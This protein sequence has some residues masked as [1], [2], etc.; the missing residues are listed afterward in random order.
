MKQV[1]RNSS[2]SFLA[3]IRR[4]VSE[5]FFAREIPYGLAVVRIFLPLAMLVPMVYRLRWV[6]ELYS[7][8]GATAQVTS[9]Y[10]YGDMLPVFPGSVAV[11]LYCAMVVLLLLTS[12]GWQTRF[13]IVGGTVLYV[14][15]NMLDAVGTSTK[16]SAIAAD[17]MLA[18]C[19][20]ESGAV[21]S[22]D[23]WRRRKSGLFRYDR[24]S[25]KSAVWPT[26]L[27]QFLLGSIYFG[28]AMTKIHTPE[29]F[30]GEQLRF[31][32]LSNV[33]FDNPFGEYLATM[34]AMLVISAYITVVWEMLFLF[35]V[36]KG[37]ARYVMLF[38][39]AIFH[40]GT[41][42]TLGLYTFPMI[43]ISGYW[44]FA[45]QKDVERLMIWTRSKALRLGFLRRRSETAAVSRS[46]WF[47]GLG[48]LPE[49]AL[50][51]VVIL[52][53]CVIGVEAEYHLDLYQVRQ[54]DGPMALKEMDPN[55]A[56]KM[57]H[58]SEPIREVDKYFSFELG[59]FMVS[60]ILSNSKREFQY[61]EPIVIQVNLNP[62]HGDLWLECNL[63]DAEGRLIERGGQIVTRKMLRANFFFTLNEVL[64]PAEYQFV[65]LSS[66]TEV[67][68]RAF[69]L[70]T[71]FT[72]RQRESIPDSSD[73]MSPAEP[74]ELNVEQFDA[75][76]QTEPIE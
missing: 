71:E 17:I 12:I 65:F 48:R 51:A 45:R 57:L 31:W 22:V 39:G 73:A 3:K 28:S 13:S 46:G 58:A 59:T 18:M 35:L 53:T 67:A 42:L 29:F 70:E 21:L 75:N 5:F 23:A 30:S 19:F 72:P 54:P 37:P 36:W 49:P 68:R 74:F 64:E 1:A 61:G 6:R 66:G 47:D 27:V 76:V 9:L 2:P 41:C 8:D 44:A 20:A 55:V 38:L 50:L 62:P 16:Y 43:C 69:A 11:A 14:Y 60:G 10:G 7:A 32:M 15:F 56:R 40:V 34:P 52:L 33:N 4:Q 24:E 63:H 25:L 26:R